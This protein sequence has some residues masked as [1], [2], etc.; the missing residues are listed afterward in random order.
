M[1]QNIKLRKRGDEPYYIFTLYLD[2]YGRRVP[3][4]GWRY[5]PKSP[6]G[7]ID[8]EK[9]E[10]PRQKIHGKYHDIHPLSEELRQDILEAARIA[11]WPH[12]IADGLVNPSKDLIEKYQADPHGFIFSSP[13]WYRRLYIMHQPPEVQD[14]FA[15]LPSERNW[16]DQYMEYVALHLKAREMPP[17]EVEFQVRAGIFKAADL[18]VLREFLAEEENAEER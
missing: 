5:W 6:P 15:A 17:A 14:A 7:V 9:V 10:G 3:S 12:L 13:E 11:C 16:P 1:I 4:C 2:W 8:F 18:K